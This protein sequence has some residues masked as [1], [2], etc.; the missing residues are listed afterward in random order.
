MNPK[1]RR[2][3]TYRDKCNI[4]QCRPRINRAGSYDCSCSWTPYG[5][6]GAEI[7][8]RGSCILHSSLLDRIYCDCAL[9]CFSDYV[10][11]PCG[12]RHIPTRTMQAAPS[13]HLHTDSSLPALS[14][15]SLLYSQDDPR[16]SP[17]EFW[18]VISSMLSNS[19]RSWLFPGLSLILTSSN[20][21]LIFSLT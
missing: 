9:H 14:F 15:F 12:C 1:A 17:L 16:R 13:A 6:E 3:Y 4:S 10:M 8:Y 11:G 2:K 21:C 5:L 19:S 20:P 7:S 18:R